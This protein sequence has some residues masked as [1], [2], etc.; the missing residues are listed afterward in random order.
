MR[1][2]VSILLGKE[3]ERFAPLLAKYIYKY[4]EGDVADYFQAKS[5]IKDSDGN[6]E[7]QKAELINTESGDFVSTTKIC[8]LAKW[9]RIRRWGQKNQMH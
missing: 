4:G 5:W 8:I 3:M 1:H 7:I 9:S 6:I 2:N